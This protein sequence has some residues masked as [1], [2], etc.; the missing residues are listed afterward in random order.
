MHKRIQHISRETDRK[1][2]TVDQEV[3][4]LLKPPFHVYSLGMIQV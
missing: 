3:S 2:P 4:R 1:K